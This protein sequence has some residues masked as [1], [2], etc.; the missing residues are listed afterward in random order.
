MQ[1]KTA[2][3]REQAQ[4]QSQVKEAIADTQKTIDEI[5]A[6]Q[7]A[8]QKKMEKLRAQMEAW[9]ARGIE[10]GYVQKKGDG[11]YN[12]DKNAAGYNENV[13]AQMKKIAAEYNATKKS[14]QDL[15]DEETLARESLAALNES[16]QESQ[17][18]TEQVTQANEQAKASSPRQELMQLRNEI[19]MLTLQWRDMT[20]AE[21]E[22]A[23]GQALKEKLD[24][25]SSKAAKL[26]DAFADV[27]SQIKID[28]SDTAAFAGI[29]QGLNLLISGFGAAEGAA[30][31]HHGA[32]N[33]RPHGPGKGNPGRS[34][35]DYAQSVPD[36]GPR[37]I[38]PLR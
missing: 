29:T 14:L 15:R 31:G 1:R 5:V 3:D 32:G 11:Q 13:V 20:D 18:Q 30:A 10:G 23:E 33:H 12:A 37:Q 28:A 7:E 25:L 36:F 27:Q 38:H 17:Q 22:S 16:L 2:A 26:Q 8:A 21:R 19:T 35:R 34:Q 24:E 6:K 4:V 9:A